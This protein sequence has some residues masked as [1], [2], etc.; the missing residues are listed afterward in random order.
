MTIRIGLIG[1]GEHSEI[2]HAV[3]LARYASTHPGAVALAA[4]CDLRPE[5][6]ELFCQK[7]GFGKAYLEM[8]E[9]LAKEKLDACISVAPVDLISKIGVAL[10]DAKI[11]CVVE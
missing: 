10:L 6:A 1:C 7:Y 9:M 8:N 5:R 4:A 11:P 2:G 3:S